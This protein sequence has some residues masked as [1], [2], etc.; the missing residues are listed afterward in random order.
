MASSFKEQQLTAEQ[1]RIRYREKF[2][3]AADPLGEATIVDAFP[4]DADGLIPITKIDSPL[5]VTIPLWTDRTEI[6]T[7]PDKLLLEYKHSGLPGYV[8]IGLEEEIPSSVPDSEFP[9]SREIPL[10]IFKSF[11]G[12]FQ[13]RYCVT[14]WNTNRREAPDSP[15]TIDRTGPVRP[16]APAAIDVVQPLI[17][18]AVLTSDGGVRCVVPDFTEDKKEFVKVA[19]G[20]MATLPEDEADFPDLVAFFNL[21]PS[22]RE[23]LV[24]KNFVTDIGSKIQYAVYFLFDKAGNR[25]EMSLPKSVQVALGE[26]PSALQP[27]TVP[28]AYD[29]LI[30]R[31][32]AAYPTTVHIDSYTGW[33]MDDGI[34][35]QWGK[36]TLARTPVSAHYPFP[37]KINM[38]WSHMAG[39]YDFDLIT[40]VQPVDVD[41]TVL[42]G[43]YPTASPANITVDT[44]FAITGPENPNPEPIN[45][46]LELI[47]F[48][49]FSGSDK[50]LTTD[51]IGEDAKGHIKLF[52]T[53]V[54]VAGDTLTLYYNGTAV[55]S[56]AYVVKG[57]ETAG[58]EIPMVIPWGD[59]EKTLVMDD[60]PMYY[61]V[62]RTGFANPQESNRTTINVELE[63]VDLPEPTFPGPIINCPLLRED[64]SG[65]WGIYVHIPTSNYLKEGVDVTL[66]WNSYEVD[67]STELP[68]TKHTEVITVNADQ[69]NKGIDWFIPNDKCLKPTYRPP[70][71][72]AGYGKAIYSINVRGTLVS[73]DLVEV[74]IGMFEEYPAGSGNNHCQLTRPPRN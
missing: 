5:K 49:S 56:P 68:G 62:T 46:D 32:D 27:C 71:S 30:D 60:L 33:D 9:L 40:H 18:D 64:V 34:V 26:L 72:S 28:L 10:D 25:S 47:Q 63:V 7:I 1:V 65:Q 4:G 55:S 57:D 50:E 38:P 39:E 45:P 6:P 37:L 20:W 67:N 69:E 2:S 48:E 58:Q 21:L 44:D 53:P 31:A 36:K 41:Y 24:P 61:T 3:T 70:T 51:D 54:P 16:G 14:D 12:T 42:R 59:I 73:S 19:V 17:T 8:P 15:I 43:D 66:D 35:I 11:E 22:T 74:V 29:G 23:I 13:F 52:E